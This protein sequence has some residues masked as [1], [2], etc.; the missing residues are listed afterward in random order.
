MQFEAM[1]NCSC[2]GVSLLA[3]SCTHTDKQLP[4]VK[5]APQE[6][7][8]ILMVCEQSEWHDMEQLYFKPV[9]VKPMCSHKMALAPSVLSYLL[10]F[11]QLPTKKRKMLKR[12]DLIIW[13]SRWLHLANVH[14]KAVIYIVNQLS[15]MYDIHIYILWYCI[16]SNYSICLCQC[17]NVQSQS[18][19]VLIFQKTFALHV[20][21]RD[22][23]PHH[24]MKQTEQSGG[25]KWD[26]SLHFTFEQH[27]SNGVHWI[28]MKSIHF[29]SRFTSNYSI[30]PQSL[31]LIL[32]LQPSMLEEV[33]G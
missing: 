4:K 32:L 14:E 17:K 25:H 12:N 27:K 16:I 31:G 23:S 10:E 2:V 20:D 9:C 11:F 6:S 29:I 24:A 26:L 21:L 7:Y 8:P 3:A 19:R 15:P 22:L 5:S 28:A 33:L 13:K 18:P 30:D 1:R